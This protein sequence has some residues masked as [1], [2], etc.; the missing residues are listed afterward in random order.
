MDVVDEVVAVVTVIVVVV[1]ASLD[2]F[3]EYTIGITT[4]I[5]SNPVRTIPPT[6][7]NGV[8]LVFDDV[9]FS[10]LSRRKSNDTVQL[11]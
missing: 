5:A 3:K 7:C 11:I 4:A 2:A 10:A 6:I 9:L 8:Y 1:V